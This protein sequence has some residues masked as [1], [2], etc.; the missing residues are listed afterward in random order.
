MPSAV[1]AAAVGSGAAVHIG[2]QPIY[3]ARR[4][5]HAYELLFRPA[6]GASTS[7]RD[8]SSGT[9]SQAEG[10]EATT[11]TILAAFSAFDLAELLSGRPGFVNLTEA[12]LVGRLPVPFPPQTAVLEVLETVRVGPE[13]LTGCRGLVAEGYRLALDDFVYRPGTDELLELAS[14][15]KVDVLGEPWDVVT[16]TAERAR[17]HGATLLAERVEDEDVLRRCADAGFELFQ[18]YHLGRPETLSAQTLTPGHAL[19]LRMLVLLSDPE[20]TADDLETL[21]RTDAALTFRLLKIA[22][23]AS[24]GRSR[25]VRSV[26]DAVVLVGLARL[27]S[28]VVLLALADRQGAG[29]GLADALVRAHACEELAREVGARGV[30]PDEAFTLGLLDGLRRSLGL[31]PHELPALMPVLDPAL[32]AALSGTASPLRSVL[33]AVDAYED[34]DLAAAA[35]S[36]WHPRHVANAY[37]TALAQTSRLEAEVRSS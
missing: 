33:D 12:F 23:S 35:A 37:L 21:L 31:D 4:R 7:Q 14:I 26:K 17:A 29:P 16:A 8:A 10:D 20:T 3:D 22:N 36:G 13:L 15:V 34:G 24:A 27:R 9:V 18:G 28:W 1:P 25:S 6:A 2:R 19:L 30:S 5:L 32:G 11:A